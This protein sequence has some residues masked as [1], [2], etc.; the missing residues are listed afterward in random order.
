VLLPAG[1]DKPIVFRQEVLNDW[2][3]RILSGFQGYGT[4]NIVSRRVAADGVRHGYRDGT[5]EAALYR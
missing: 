5:D 2:S 4:G 1:A 3:D